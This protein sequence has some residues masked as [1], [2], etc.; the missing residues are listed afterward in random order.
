M[1]TPEQQHTCDITTTFGNLWQLIS[2]ASTLS[3][4]TIHKCEAILRKFAKTTPVA[5]DA[6]TKLQH[7]I[8]VLKAAEWYRSLTQDEREA[9][10]FYASLESLSLARDKAEA[11]VKR[12]TH[13]LERLSPLAPLK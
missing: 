5:N 8:A 1:M 3:E 4:E 11:E 2:P 10:E 13:E 6:A 12:L 9:A 7:E